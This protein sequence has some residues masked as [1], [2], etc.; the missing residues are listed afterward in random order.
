MEKIREDKNAKP[1]EQ[2]KPLGAKLKR[3][4][5]ENLMRGQQ[6]IHQ[7]QPQDQEIAQYA[8]P[9][10]LIEGGG[11]GQ[12][13]SRNK[14]A[15]EQSLTAGDVVKKPSREITQAPSQIHHQNVGQVPHIQSTQVHH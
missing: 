11:K 14:K 4:S 9:T 13:Q 2:N 5:K 3:K 12:S 15:L 6:E 1:P 7:A 10:G 8:A